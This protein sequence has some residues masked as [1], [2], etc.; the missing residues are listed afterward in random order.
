MSGWTHTDFEG[1][2]IQECSEG[3]TKLSK[4]NLDCW[5][6]PNE[7][8]KDGVEEEKDGVEAQRAGWQ[9][10]EPALFPMPQS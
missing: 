9:F 8:E 3:D 10:G 7:E 5:I 4:G 1:E 6:S 2:E